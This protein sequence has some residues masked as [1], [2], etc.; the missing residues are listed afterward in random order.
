MCPSKL[1]TKIIAHACSCIF[2]ISKQNLPPPRVGKFAWCCR[3][4][5]CVGRQSMKK[6]PPTTLHKLVFVSTSTH[7]LSRTLNSQLISREHPNIEILW[8]VINGDRIAT[9]DTNCEV[10][11][12]D[13]GLLEQFS[14][15]MQASVMSWTA[16]RYIKSFIQH[17]LSL[18]EAELRPAISREGTFQR[19]HVQ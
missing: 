16:D 6:C 8:A 17:F 11:E 19:Q 2:I 18:E 4:V 10:S 12:E 1:Q 13:P 15:C 7:L 14:A 5:W 3:P 9:E